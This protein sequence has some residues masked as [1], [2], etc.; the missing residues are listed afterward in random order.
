MTERKRV[1][2]GIQNTGDIH[3]GNYIGALRNWVKLQD[4]YDAI[5]CVVDLH[6]ITIPF[7]PEAL[8]KSRLETAKALLAV[9]IDPDRSLLYYQSQVPQH[10]ELAWII[11]V[12]TP[13]G[14]LNRMTQF[15]EKSDRAGQ[16][17]GL[18]AYPV[19]MAADI[20]IH[21]VHAVPVGDDQTQ[22]LEFTRDVAVRFNGKYGDTFPVPEQVTPEVGARI[23]S[24]Q[25]PV[26]KMSKSDPDVSSRILVFDH[27][28]TIV[29]KC[30]RAVTDSGSDVYYDV[31]EKPGISNLLEI[32]SIFTER[33]I[34]DLVTEYGSMQYG[35]FKQVVADAIVEGLAPIRSVYQALDDGEVKRIMAK[36]MLDARMRAEETMVDVRRRIGL[37]G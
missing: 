32:L 3:I 20:L 14:A 21:K 34:D 12:D 27:P 7:E 24:L 28:D 8:Q 19:L 16:R 36:G 5:Y 30:R 15:K 23:M 26:N 4:T 2:S 31:A 22:H 33:P 25:D 35:V 1:F 11:G 9:G 37:A 6:S 17:Y 10:P 13:M 18:F 29:K